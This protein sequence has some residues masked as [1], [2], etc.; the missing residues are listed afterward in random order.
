MTL[1]TTYNPEGETYCPHCE[2]LVKCA[3]IG[4]ITFGSNPYLDFYHEECGTEWRLY[5]IENRIECPIPRPMTLREMMGEDN[6]HRQQEKEH[7]Q[8]FAME[9]LS[10]LKSIQSGFSSAERID[11]LIKRATYVRSSD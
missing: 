9:M 5:I 6:W 2:K 7:V 11:D 10:L 1:V 3:N 8:R 4:G